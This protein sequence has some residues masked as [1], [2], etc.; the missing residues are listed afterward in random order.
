MQ[1]VQQPDLSDV[2]IPANERKIKNRKIELGY[3]KISRHY[4]WALSQVFDQL[5]FKYVIIVEGKG[6]IYGVCG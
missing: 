4:K 6:W 3:Y 5:Q 1:H 2:Q